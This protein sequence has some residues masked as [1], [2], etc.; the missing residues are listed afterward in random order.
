MIIHRCNN[1]KSRHYL[2]LLVVALQLVGA[3]VAATVMP[4]RTLGDLL[5]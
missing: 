4:E 2:G 3:V 1:G 5:Q